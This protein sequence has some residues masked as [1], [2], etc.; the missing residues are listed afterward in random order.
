MDEFT[1]ARRGAHVSVPLLRLDHALLTKE[2][3]PLEPGI[4]DHKYYV[5]DIGDV[6][7]LT[8]KGGQERLHL[9]AVSHLPRR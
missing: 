1:V 9:V 7:E 3:S 2:T 4:V 8:V 5:R 6:R